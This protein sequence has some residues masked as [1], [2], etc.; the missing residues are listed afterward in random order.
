MRVKGEVTRGCEKKSPRGEDE[1]R[2][3]IAREG[4]K[5][6]RSKVSSQSKALVDLQEEQRQSRTQSHLKRL[7]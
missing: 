1:G 3:E 7:L 2:G 5:E 4:T 6:G